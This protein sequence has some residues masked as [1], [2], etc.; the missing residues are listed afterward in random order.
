M[1]YK[2]FFAI[3]PHNTNSF[4]VTAQQI[5]VGGTGNITFIDKTGATILIENLAVGW[6]PIST[7]KITASGT[8][9]TKLVGAY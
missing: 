9:A 5:Y 1:S 8:T 4:A 3:T 7:K 2:N 6:H